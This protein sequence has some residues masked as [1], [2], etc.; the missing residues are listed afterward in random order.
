MAH[1]KRLARPGGRE[2]ASRSKAAINRGKSG[3][4]P[5]VA[6]VA[7]DLALVFGPPEALVNGESD[8]PGGF[9]RPSQ[10]QIRR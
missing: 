7:H 9:P 1:A 10:G 5:P 8:Q 4:R 6:S 2:L 3:A